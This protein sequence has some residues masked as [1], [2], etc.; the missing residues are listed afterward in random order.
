M[1]S[2]RKDRIKDMK[3]EFNPNLKFHVG[4]REVS[5]RKG[6]RAGLPVGFSL[7]GT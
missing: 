7:V 3:V 4:Q 5:C 6:A 2:I 1:A